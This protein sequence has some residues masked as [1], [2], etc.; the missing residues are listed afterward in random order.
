MG[1]QE[2]LCCDFLLSSFVIY[3]QCLL[4]EFSTLII[5]QYFLFNSV[6]CFH[7][8]EGESRALIYNYV[9]CNVCERR[10]R[11]FI[12]LYLQTPSIKSSNPFFIV[13]KMFLYAQPICQEK[14]ILF[15]KPSVELPSI[16]H[17]E[18][19]SNNPGQR[20]LSPTLPSQ[21][22]PAED[23]SARNKETH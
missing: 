17:E 5:Q 20:N 13:L 2:L 18:V 22:P 4:H 3:Q 23:K 8:G 6:F 14:K 19:V 15:G 21:I 12:L 1:D 16:V 11:V 10:G 9:L 7:C